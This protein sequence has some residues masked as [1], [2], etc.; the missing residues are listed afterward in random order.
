MTHEEQHDINPRP[1]DTCPMLDDILS[2]LSEITDDS[3]Y[4]T[5]KAVGVVK[6]SDNF[7]VGF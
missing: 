2:E 3:K 5:T 7:S 4:P 6:K 1:V